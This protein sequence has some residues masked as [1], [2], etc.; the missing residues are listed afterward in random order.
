MFSLVLKNIGKKNLRKRNIMTRI[1]AAS[2]L[3]LVLLAGC[4]TGTANKVS[5]YSVYAPPKVGTVLEYTAYAAGEP[6]LNLKQVVVE[7]GSDYAL[8][9]NVSETGKPP[10]EEDF[11][12]EFSGVYWQV[13]G[14]VM[15][16]ASE[17]QSLQ[18]LWPIQQGNSTILS[19]TDLAGKPIPVD[20]SVVSTKISEDI[21]F[22][23]LPAFDVKTTF[24]V[25]ETTTFIPELSV[26]SRIEWGVPG[27]E[28]YAG[29]DQLVSVAQAEAGQYE[30]YVSFGKSRCLPAALR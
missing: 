16:S 14:D 22:G 18:T 12:L 3:S 11:F 4:A 29:Y 1:F 28:N 19:G 20:V 8:Y 26:A 23:A 15:P 6:D 27:T 25:P 5:P 30:D 21:G 10:A 9:A 17:R 2:T 13:C 24:D 7:S